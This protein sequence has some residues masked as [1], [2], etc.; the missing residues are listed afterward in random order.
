MSF[1]SIA[2][3]LEHY[4]A[5]RLA[6]AQHFHAAQQSHLQGGKWCFEHSLDGVSA[7]STPERQP[8]ALCRSLCST[9]GTF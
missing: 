2:D 9:K 1:R 7:L 5:L 3:M 4:S 6:Q 8:H